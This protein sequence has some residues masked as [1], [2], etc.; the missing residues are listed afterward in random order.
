M[1]TYREGKGVGGEKRK[2]WGRRGR[3]EGERCG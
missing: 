1:R 3:D 2:E